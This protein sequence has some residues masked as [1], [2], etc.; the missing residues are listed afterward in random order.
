MLICTVNCKRQITL[1]GSLLIFLVLM[2]AGGQ[3]VLSQPKN[4]DTVEKTI[5]ATL[6]VELMCSGSPAFGYAAVSKQT[7]P[8]RLEVEGPA[9]RIQ[10]MNSVKTHP[11]N[12]TGAV[13]TIEKEVPLDLPEDIGLARNE[14]NTRIRGKVV[15]EKQLVE[16]T[17][18]NV[19]VQMANNLYPGIVQPNSV[20]ITIRGTMLFFTNDFS[21]EDIRVGVDLKG[22][23]PG[24]HVL[25][26][27]IRLPEQ[28]GLLGVDPQVFTVRILPQTSN[29]SGKNDAAG[30]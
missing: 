3:T 17:F 7:Q 10:K 25:P 4:I 20:T 6:P 11:V 14:K 5:Q 12:I 1:A 15:I 8:A 29:T 23:G 26:V 9:N 28:T 16:K 27:Q 24:I 22:M 21:P 18:E 30:T 13:N 2:L 19:P